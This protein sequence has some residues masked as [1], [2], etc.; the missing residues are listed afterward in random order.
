[1]LQFISRS[2]SQSPPSAEVRNRYPTV[3]FIGTG[4]PRNRW[5]GFV[6]PAA[7]RPI[8]RMSGS[9]KDWFATDPVIVPR[10][11]PASGVA[12]GG[13]TT[14]DVAGGGGGGGTTSGTRSTSHPLGRAMTTCAITVSRPDPQST[15]SAVDST[16]IVSLP[17]PPISRSA[18]P[19][20]VS[21]SI[22]RVAVEAVLPAAAD[23][24]VITRPAADRVIAPGAAQVVAPRRAR[25]VAGLCLRGQATHQKSHHDCRT[26]LASHRSTSVWSSR[27]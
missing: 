21:R 4:V 12:G 5:T 26:S 20:P 24:A 14:G 6:S 23:E 7:G 1:M 16:T 22:A 25:D 3:V 8:S 10:H 18:P 19:P 27:R 13:W 11:A 9:E 2:Q 15:R 17:D